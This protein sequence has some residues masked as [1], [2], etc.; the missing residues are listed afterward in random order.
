MAARAGKLDVVKLLIEAG[1]DIEKSTFERATPLY[2]AAGF[3]K[4]R[5]SFLTFLK[6]KS[7]GILLWFLI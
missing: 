3:S 2:V 1:A 7:L 4:V 5:I 6:F